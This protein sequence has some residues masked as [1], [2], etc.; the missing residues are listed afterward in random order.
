MSMSTA[1]HRPVASSVGTPNAEPMDSRVSPQLLV[2][3][4]APL[5]WGSTPLE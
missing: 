3:E 5:L 2:F 4:M 1:A